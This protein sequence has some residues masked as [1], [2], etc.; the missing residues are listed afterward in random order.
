M[1][2]LIHANQTMRYLFLTILS[3][4]ISCTKQ[5]SAP[6]TFSL[7]GTVHLEGQEDHSGVTVA[8]YNLVELDMAVVRLQKEFPFVGAD[9]FEMGE[10]NTPCY[11][12]WRQI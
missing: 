1:H 4:A 3:I 7:S 8:L 11:V 5:P 10:T 2:P 9:L 12:F 6:S